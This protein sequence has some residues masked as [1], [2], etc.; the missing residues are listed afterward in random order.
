MLH[1]H[2]RSRSSSDYYFVACKRVLIV[3][4][5]CKD[6]IIVCGGGEGGGN[7]WSEVKYEIRPGL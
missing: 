2:F 7:L 5:V 3:M 6:N 4:C 1:M